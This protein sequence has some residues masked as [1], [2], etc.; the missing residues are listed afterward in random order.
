MNTLFNII[1]QSFKYITKVDD[2]IIDLSICKF[3]INEQMFKDI[4]RLNSCFLQDTGIELPEEEGFL[5]SLG[6]HTG[7]LWQGKKN[8][9][10]CMGMINFGNLD[11]VFQIKSNK[12]I[13]NTTD[14]LTDECISIL[15]NS[16]YFD[17][18]FNWDTFTLLY[19][20]KG[21]TYPKLYYYHHRTLHLLPFTIS[22]YL[23]KA[24]FHKGSYYWQ[25][26]YI[27]DKSN[28]TNDDLEIYNSNILF[29]KL[30]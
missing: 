24:I 14:Y 28:F 26:N 29:S 1:D 27:K 6:E 12:Y 10:N 11:N 3:Q 13:L 16:Y 5:L 21:M 19:H 9:E 15:Q 30:I 7:Y 20:K 17:T 22:E 25:I 8:Y 18:Y 2:Q 4:S 23:E